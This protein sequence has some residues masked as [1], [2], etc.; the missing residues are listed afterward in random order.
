[1]SIPRR[2]PNLTVKDLKKA[3]NKFRDARHA[4]W[5]M[6]HK[7]GLIDGAVVWGPNDR[8]FAYNLYARRICKRT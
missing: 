7:T 4:Y 1:M 5:E 3:A 8:W 2:D 6:A